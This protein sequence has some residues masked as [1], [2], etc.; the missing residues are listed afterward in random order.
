M[1]THSLWPAAVA[2]LLTPACVVHVRD[3]EIQM[4]RDAHRAVSTSAAPL[5]QAHYSQAIVV[6]DTLYA[7]GQIGTDPRTGEIVPGGTAA[8]TRQALENLRQVLE[9]GGF[10]F[11]DVAQAQVFLADMDDFADMNAVYAGYFPGSPPARAAVAVA[12]LPKGARVEILLVA[13]RRD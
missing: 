13:R 4:Q 7:S 9:A 10:S 8:E 1:I 11:A 6:D 3:G 2:L 12:A 5:P